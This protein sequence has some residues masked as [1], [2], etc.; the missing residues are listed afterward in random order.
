MFIFLFFS[1]CPG[2]EAQPG[3]VPGPRQHGGHSHQDEQP[4]GG[5][6]GG[7]KAG[8]ATTLLRQ[9]DH[10]FMPKFF[11]Y[12]IMPLFAVAAPFCH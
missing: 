2:G 1:H 10:V 5:R 7:C 3:Q 12:C 8:H 4:G 6:Q 9:R 11:V